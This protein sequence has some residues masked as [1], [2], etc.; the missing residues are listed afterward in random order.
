MYVM[1]QCGTFTQYCK[2]RC[3]RWD[4]NGRIIGS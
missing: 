2:R 1:W 3:R 4:F